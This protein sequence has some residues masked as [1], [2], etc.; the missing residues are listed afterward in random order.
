MGLHIPECGEPFDRQRDHV[1]A[2]RSQASPLN[3]TP[4]LPPPPSS[5]MP[6]SCLCTPAR[7]SGMINLKVSFSGGFGAASCLPAPHRGYLHVFLR[8]FWAWWKP[9]ASLPRLFYPP[10]SLGPQSL[11]APSRLSWSHSVLL[12]LASS[13]CGLWTLP[14]PFIKNPLP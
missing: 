9:P 1:L 14:F 7:S 3:Y 13:L 2:P 8:L 11:R 10:S 4:L 6:P 12:P 5:Q